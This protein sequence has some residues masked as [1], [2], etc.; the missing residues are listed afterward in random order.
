MNKLKQLIEKEIPQAIETMSSLQIVNLINMERNL[1]NGESATLTHTHFMQKVPMVIGAQDAA[2]FRSI[3]NDSMN[4]EKPC[5][6]FPK[7]ETMLML[8]SYSYDLQKVVYD[9]MEE[10]ENKPAIALPDFNS[11]ADAARAWAIEYEAKQAALLQLDHAIAT[12][13]EIGNK[14]E[15]TAMNTA[16]QAV[17]RANKLEQELDQ[18]KQ[19]STIKRMEIITGLKFNWRILK[20]AGQDLQ[21][22]PVA[23]PDQNYGT[24]KAYHADVWQEAYALDINQ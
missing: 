14:R 23:V 18:S 21:I 16:S 22:E 6:R 9:R 5:Y 20:S 13:A 12:K 10:L 11:P 1:R 24:V 19:W 8:M 2:N 7:R 4:R 17:K 3:Y 15:A